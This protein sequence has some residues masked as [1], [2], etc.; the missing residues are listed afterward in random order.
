MLTRLEVSGFKNLLDLRVEFGP[1]TCIAG[2]NGTGKS[3]VFDAIQFLS[4]LTDHSMIEAAQAVRGTHGTLHG[5]ARDLFWNGYAD[6]EHLMKFAAEMIVP[7]EAEDDFGRLAEPTST[8]L[9]YEVHLG[10]QPPQGG[11][12]GGRLTL[13]YEDL[14]RIRPS[15][16]PSHLRFP[17]SARDF[18]GG[19]VRGRR[20]TA[21]YI[22]TSFELGNATV[23]I[24]ADGSS[25]GK[26]RPAPASRAPQTML[27][28]VNR[29]D[30]PTILTARREMQSWRRLALEPSALRTSDRYSDP[31][32][33]QPDGLHLPR[34]LDRIARK[35]SPDDPARIY[36]RVA[37]RLSDLSGLHVRT[38]HVE[39]DDTR[40]LLTIKLHEI[41]GM[42]LPARSLSEGTLRFLALCVLLEDPQAH[43]LLCMEEPENGIHPANLPAMVDLVR[44]LAVD[45][46]LPVDEDNPFRQVLIN[47]H[48]PGVV[49][50]ADPAD[51]LI[52]D[53]TTVPGADGK[54]ARGL[55]L[56]PLADTWRAGG[57]G[58]GYG[59]KAD[60]LAYLTVPPEARLTLEESAS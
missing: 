36:S 59:T 53:T 37:G 26:P 22:S 30:D 42:V 18:R 45:P 9:R 15:E 55:R 31:S 60:I 41:D 35:K 50:L 38:L 43:G 28:T 10:Y 46:S 1:F 56:R 54:A 32:E 24:H 52:A 8:F 47:T 29:N 12:R 49:A 5:D 57:A 27:S 3:N 25:G 19:V 21:P 13:R 48:S 44:D 16:A 14:S 20:S 7:G 58:K 17:H 4:L 6:G 34:S 33:M 11:E 51:L 23:R 2:E 39:A 40:E